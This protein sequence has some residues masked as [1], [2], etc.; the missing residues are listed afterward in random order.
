MAPHMCAAAYSSAST[1][2]ADFPPIH[3]LTLS[4]GPRAARFSRRWQNL[5]QSA[6]RKFFQPMSAAHAHSAVRAYNSSETA[7]LTFWIWM[8]LSK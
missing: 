3:W 1:S 5:V 7:L 4:P 8:K 2:L 6:S